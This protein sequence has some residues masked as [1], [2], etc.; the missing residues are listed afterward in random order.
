MGE[1]REEQG[2]LYAEMGL[3]MGRVGWHIQGGI[4]PFDQNKQPWPYEKIV[5]H[6]L[7]IVYNGDHWLDMKS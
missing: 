5:K 3:S 1:I 7:S 6:D 4:Q 2:R